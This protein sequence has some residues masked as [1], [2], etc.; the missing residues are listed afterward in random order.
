MKNLLFAVCTLLGIVACGQKT[1]SSESEKAPARQIAPGDSTRYGLACDGCTDSIL[2]LLPAEGGDPDTFD[3]IT[4]RQQHL[5]FGHP[6][7]GDELAVILNPEDK[8]EAQMVINI[9]RLKGEWCYQVMPTFRNIQSMPQ[10]MQRR[11]MERIPD[12]VKE[13]LVVPRE[14]GIRLKRNNLAQTVGASRNRN[15]NSMSPVEYPKAK[16]YAMW[17]LYNGRLI[18]ET[19]TARLS[20]NSEKRRLECDTADIVLLRRDSLVLRFKDHEQSYYRKKESSNH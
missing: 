8:N 4:A 6:Q 10:K 14:Y 9:E 1:A 3:I 5:V 7:I 17:R 16:R 19:D 11:M 18:L 2:I 15:D 13:R 20:T 12:S